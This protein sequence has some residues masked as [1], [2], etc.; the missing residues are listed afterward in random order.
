MVGV[1]QG[2]THTEAAEHLP[3]VVEGGVEREERGGCDRRG[4]AEDGELWLE[5]RRHHPPQ[6][7][8]EH[9][10]YGDAERHPE[11]SGH[12]R[13]QPRRS[14]LRLPPP[15]QLKP[16][17]LRHPPSTAGRRWRRATTSTVAEEYHGYRRC[18]ARVQE[19][20]GLLV[21]VVHHEQRAVAGPAPGH[22]VGGGELL[23]AEDRDYDHHEHGGSRQERERHEPE[24]LPR[25][26]AVHCGGLGIGPPV[27]PAARP[28][29]GSS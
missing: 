12:R 29:T 21:E 3:V 8:D 14:L 6:R 20:E 25:S 26:C 19:A 4:V 15:G 22:H 10:R 24:P 27:W 18:V 23:E 11:V 2:A 16:G 9:Q 7:G 28:R 17:H 13:A 1:D 5:R